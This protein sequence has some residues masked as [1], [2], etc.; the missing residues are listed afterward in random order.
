[1]PSV[2][3]IGAGRMGYEMAARLARGGADVLVWNRTCAKAEPLAQHGAKIAGKLAELAARDVVFCMVA[4]WKDVKQVIGEL[5][6]PP[7]STSSSLSPER[8]TTV[9]AAA[10]SASTVDTTSSRQ[11]GRGD[12]DTAPTVTPR[13]DRPHVGGSTA[14]RSGV[15]RRRLVRSG[16][17][18]ARGGGRRPD[19]PVR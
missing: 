13:V 9:P 7:V 15:G 12:S 11:V 10:S 6:S 18:S 17:A 8:S 19:L 16:G 14:G 5:L 4:T 3:W 2:G 1:M